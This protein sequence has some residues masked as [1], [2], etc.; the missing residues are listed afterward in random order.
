MGL[1]ISITADQDGVRQELAR[2]IEEENGRAKRADLQRDQR[3]HR[4]FASG[5]R[6]A[7]E[8]VDAAIRSEEAGGV[9]VELRRADDIIAEVGA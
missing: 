4:A 9:A 7:L 3:Y 5:L 6:E 8:V 2:R 1:R